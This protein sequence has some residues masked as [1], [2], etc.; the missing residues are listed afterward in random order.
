[1]AMGPEK[2]TSKGVAEEVALRPT[3]STGRIE[4]NV[5]LPDSREVPSPGP[6]AAV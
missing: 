2:E 6:L 4:K 5:V 1:M 3:A